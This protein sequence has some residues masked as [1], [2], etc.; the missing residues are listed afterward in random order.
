MIN[1]SMPNLN[2]WRTNFFILSLFFSMCCVFTVQ[3]QNLSVSKSGMSRAALPTHELFF[4][5]LSGSTADRVDIYASTGHTSSPSIAVSLIKGQSGWTD[6][7]LESVNEYHWVVEVGE[8]YGAGPKCETY[9]IWDPNELYSIEINALE[10]GQVEHTISLLYM[11][12]DLDWD[13]TTPHKEANGFYC[14]YADTANK[15]DLAIELD[16][17]GFGVVP[18]DLGS[19]DYEYLGAKFT[20]DDKWIYPHHLIDYCASA[21]ITGGNGSVESC[22]GESKNTKYFVMTFQTTLDDYTLTADADLELVEEAPAANPIVYWGDVKLTFADDTELI[23]GDDVTLILDGTEINLDGQYGAFTAIR[24]SFI[25]L[26]GGAEIAGDASDSY[27]QQIVFEGNGSGTTGYDL[28][29]SGNATFKHVYATLEDGN[30]GVVKNG[31]TLYMDG[32]TS[33]RSKFSIDGYLL[34]ESGGLIQCLGTGTELIGDGVNW[35]QSDNIEDLNPNSAGID[36]NCSGACIVADNGGSVRFNTG[37]TLT[38]EDGGFLALKNGGQIVLESNAEMIFKSDAGDYDIDAGATF[39][40]GEN[41]LITFDKALD[42]TGTSS[43]PI[44]FERLDPNESWDYLDLKADGNTLEYVVFDGGTKNIHVRSTNNT[45]TNITSKNGENGLSAAADF[46]S[47]RSSFTLEDSYLRDNSNDGLVAVNSNVTITGTEIT[48]S[49]EAGMSLTSSTIIN[50]DDNLI[51]DNASSAASA[52]G[53][54]VLSGA[55]FYM[56]DEANNTIRDNGGDE[57]LA[58]SSGQIHAGKWLGECEGGPPPCGGG[59]FNDIYDSSDPGTTYKYIDNDSSY[60]AD[61]EKNYWGETPT[62]ALFD[63]SVDY[64]PYSSVSVGAYK[65]GSLTP[66]MTL[67]KTIAELRVRLQETGLGVDA[68]SLARLYSLQKADQKD[69]FGESERTIGYFENLV[70]AFAGVD[71]SRSSGSIQAASDRAILIVFQEYM[72]TEDFESAVHLLADHHA[73]MSGVKE[74][75]EFIL[76]AVLL[77]DYFGQTATANSYF[78]ELS[79]LSGN[80]DHEQRE[81]DVLAR[82]LSFSG[83]IEHSDRNSPRVFPSL[84]R[85]A[86]SKTVQSDVS[87]TSE[88]SLYPNPA[89]PNTVVRFVL[90]EKSAVEIEFVDILGRTIQK[91]SILSAQPGSHTV[92]V[93][94]SRFASGQYLVRLVVVGEN[95]VGRA[96]ET[97]KLI[98]MK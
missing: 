77:A 70:S 32:S 10:S 57:I 61:A 3:A 23:V 5:I 88:L 68:E 78:T 22:E 67:G 81:L 25:E 79:K 83:R 51:E 8:I 42:L 63:G 90:A 60:G 2:P 29:I 64:T 66:R 53:V 12:C 72:G 14:L 17:D 50:L 82:E 41:A 28:T 16:P 52:G 74:R 84:S 33:R 6:V 18:V 76:S 47:G 98:V 54:E 31:A 59:G 91:K 44:V 65:A 35:N 30:D 96:T 49:G 13:D 4:E 95:G 20:S 69:R 48:G 27:D 86:A 21:V 92:N 24:G 87:D 36:M 11:N 94:L 38:F 37:S 73:K 58:T 45:F 89:N 34:I 19:D 1:L 80:S 56:D 93:D 97:R 15:A 46:V 62:S 7:C 9:D 40:L 43:N 71:L 85:S 55:W 75:S 26:T 39:K